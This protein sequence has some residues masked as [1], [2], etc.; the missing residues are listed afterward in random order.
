MMEEEVVRR[1]KWLTEE[2]F[3]DLVGMTN[4]IPGPNSTEMAIHIGHQRAGFPGLIVAGTAFILPA[5][6]IT[7][8][9]AWAYVTYGSYPKALAILYG[10]KP[11]VIAIV[12]QALFG[13]AKKAVKNRLLGALGILAVIA[14]VFG[15]NELLVLLA[16]GLAAVSMHRRDASPMLL[17]VPSFSVPFTL[18]GLF[19]VFAKIGCV[20]FGSGYVLLAFLRTD[21]VEQRHWLTETQL[22]D[23]IAV[24]QLT[25]GPVFTTATFVGYVLGRSRGAVLATLGIFLPAFV[26]VALSGPLLPRI[27]RSKWAGSF[28]DGVN[29][30]SLALMAVVTVRLG[31]AALIDPL[32]IVLALASA[33]LLFRY[34]LNATWIIA[35]GAIA[36]IARTLVR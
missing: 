6:L 13:L 27:R 33:L 4:L 7:S 17:A 36:G 22:V 12:A 35:G 9:L 5:A 28:L 11:V 25:P 15:A 29:V 18:P 3:L 20:I 19:L 30:A 26:F 23:A 2:K 31:R 1:R 24:G 16:C 10:V 21:L 8:A 34:K 32:T 14:T